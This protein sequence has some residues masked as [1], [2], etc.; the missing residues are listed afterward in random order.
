MKIALTYIGNDSRNR[1]I[2]KDR[3]GKLFV[4]VDPRK[5]RKPE[6]CTKYNNDFDGE[7]DIPINYTIAYS[8]VEIEFIPIRIVW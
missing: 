3:Y 1:P 5:N 7:P 2:Y 4:D 8:N 6:I